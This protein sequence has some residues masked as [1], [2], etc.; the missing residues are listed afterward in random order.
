MVILSSVFFKAEGWKYAL[1][2]FVV[3]KINEELDFSL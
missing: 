1:I 3:L 2:F